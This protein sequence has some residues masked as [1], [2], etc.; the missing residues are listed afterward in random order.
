MLFTINSLSELSTATLLKLR[1]IPFVNGVRFLVI[2]MRSPTQDGLLEQFLEATV[3]P[4][5][6]Y[7]LASRGSDGQVMHGIKVDFSAILPDSQLFKEIR[8]S[9]GRG[10]LSTVEDDIFPKAI[11]AVAS[12]ALEIAEQ[13]AQDLKVQYFPTEKRNGVPVIPKHVFSKIGNIGLASVVVLEDVINSGT[14]SGRIIEELRGVG[15]AVPRLYGIFQR[16]AHPRYLESRGIAYSSL[17]RRDLLSY[18]AND[19]LFCQDNL[20]LIPRSVQPR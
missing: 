20:P 16:T 4:R 10:I 1:G 3:D 2:I 18:P 17:L 7:E 14:T 6:H 11:I 13:V 5:V 12:G 9:V 19:C 15:V 8:R